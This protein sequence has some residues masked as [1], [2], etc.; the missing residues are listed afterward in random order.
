MLET[1]ILQYVL[2]DPAIV[3]KR[4]LLSIPLIGWVLRRLGH[5]G[6][7]RAGGLEAARGMRDAAMSAHRE[8]RPVVIFP[9]GSRRSLGEAAD[10]KSGVDLLY[11][12]LKCPCVPVAVNSGRVLERNS[13]SPEPGRVTIEFLPLIDRGLPR[14]VFAERLKEDIE[15]ATERLLNNG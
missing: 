3:L 14:A 7:D 1:L 12:L 13:L 10:Y 15:V 9:E 6:V 4:E 8:G 5:I 11:V 2:N